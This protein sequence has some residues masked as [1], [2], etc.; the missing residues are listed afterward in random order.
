MRA[1]RP[2]GQNV[3]KT[4]SAC[5]LLIVR[6]EFKLQICKTE[7]QEKQERMARIRKSQFAGSVRS[8]KN[9]NLQFSLGQIAD[10]RTN[11]QCMVWKNAIWRTN[12]RIHFKIL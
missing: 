7:V 12:K 10:H 9:Q 6:L 4:E 11:L 1:S 2:G 8:D 3:N 5:E